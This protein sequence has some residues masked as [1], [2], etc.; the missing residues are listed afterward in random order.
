MVTQKDL[1]IAQQLFGN[2]KSNPNNNKNNF[3]IWGIINF[4]IILGVVTIINGNLISVITW[5]LDLI[6]SQY[7]KQI[8]LYLIVFIID[9][10]LMMILNDSQVIL[11]GTL[12]TILYFVIDY[13][14]LASSQFTT[15]SLI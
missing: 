13:Y 14:Y 5:F 11:S 10:I 6:V 9:L 1:L 2:T 15:F 12:A 3:L 7:S 8:L 4:I